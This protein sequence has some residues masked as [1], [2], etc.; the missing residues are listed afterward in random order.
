MIDG[1]V[2]VAGVSSQT[3]YINSRDIERSM[4]PA[5]SLTMPAAGHVGAWR[6][7]WQLPPPASAV[8]PCRTLTASMP[9]TP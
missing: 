7:T 5:N 8:R 6:E 4:Y 1:A 9:S 3:N 2:Q